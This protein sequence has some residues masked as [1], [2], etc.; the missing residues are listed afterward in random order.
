MYHLWMGGILKESTER[1]D[2]G[3]KVSKGTAVGSREEWMEKMD[4]VQEMWD[5]E[6]GGFTSLPETGAVG[7]TTR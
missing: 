1:D 7:P 4:E 3:S 2:M 6:K 5:E